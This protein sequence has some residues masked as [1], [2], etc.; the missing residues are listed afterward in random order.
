MISWHDETIRKNLR[1]LR[2]NPKGGAVVAAGVAVDGAVAG[3]TP[4]DSKGRLNWDWIADV[5]ERYTGKAVSPETLRTDWFGNRREP[6]KYTWGQILGLTQALGVSVFDIVLPDPDSRAWL[7]LSSAF[8]IPK[9]RLAAL[10]RRQWSIE[11]RK[12][13]I[14]RDAIEYHPWIRTAHDE[15]EEAIQNGIPNDF[16]A[17][18]WYNQ[19]KDRYNRLEALIRGGG[20][21]SPELEALA[22]SLHSEGYLTFDAAEWGIPQDQALESLTEPPWALRQVPKV[23]AE[24]ILYE[25]GVLVRKKE[26]DD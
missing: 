7:D 9:E 4:I 8:D 1:A 19:L 12:Q 25:L 2:E 24:Q 17:E 20:K 3:V 21:S 18:T 16:A 5:Y 13:D 14:L 6:P 11:M 26:G 23:R 15:Y 22:K 10:P